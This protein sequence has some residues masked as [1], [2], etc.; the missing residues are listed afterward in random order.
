MIVVVFWNNVPS[1]AIDS[2]LKK[3]YDAYKQDYMSSDGRIMDPQRNNATTSEGQAYMLLRSVLINDRKTFD[4]V[5]KWSK[6]NLQRE[7][8]LFSWLWGKN[9]SGEYKTLDANSASDA[10][11]DNAFALVLAHKKW[12]NKKYSDFALPI[13][14]SIW[15]N[16]TK[17]IDG[18]IVLM[19]GV[20]QTH[21]DVIEINPSYFSPYAFKI[22]KKYDRNHDW[23][24]LVDSSYHYL[25]LACDNS[26]IGLP[27]DWAT[28]KNG[29]LE[30]V[31]TD[32]DSFSYDAIRVFPRIFIDYAKTKDKRAKAIL[33]KSIFFITQWKD[34]KTL[35]TSYL[36]DGELKDKTE[37]IG[38]IALLIST[39]NIFDKKVAEEIYKDKLLPLSKEKGYYSNKN[40]YYGRN[41]VWF[42]YYLY[43]F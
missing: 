28:I 39:I 36:A 3:E 40:D 7:D 19:P 13:I 37:Y 18:Y 35:H 22:F 15:E 24:K 30:R 8:K 21:S 43:Q 17:K 4:L 32:R 33:D 41:L 5:L 16:E 34:T 11:V 31:N 27:P 26:K 42:G 2:N 9:Q 25:T 29:K 14:N 10:D 6:D 1:E 12:K 38:S 20:A 23:N